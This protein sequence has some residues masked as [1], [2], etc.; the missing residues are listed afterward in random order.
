MSA[1][2]EGTA[3]LDLEERL[4]LALEA[5]RDAGG[6]GGQSGHLPER[7]AAVVVF[8]IQ[9][10]SDWDLRVDM[11]DDAV[12]ELRRVTEGFKPNAA[13]YLE[14]ARKPQNAIPAMEFADI[15]EADKTKKVCTM[16]YSIIARCPR[17]GKLGIGTTTFSIACGRRNESVRPNVGISKSQ[18]MYMR[19]DDPRAL[20]LLKIG[21]KPE[22]RHED[23]GR[24]RR[25]LGLSPDR[26]HRSRRQCGRSYR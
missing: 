4:L 12:S 2:F 18:A 1:R 11:H 24:E 9:P 16:T 19:A 14:R 13:Y 5:G 17:T 10:Y 8:G 15:L 20:N 22:L 21:F 3:A 25:R 6:Q 23:A 7:S 26:N